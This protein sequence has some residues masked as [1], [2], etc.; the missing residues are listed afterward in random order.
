VNDA[1]PNAYGCICE[2]VREAVLFLDKG[3]V[4]KII[5]KC[6][7]IR[8]EE[9]GLGWPGSSYVP[10]TALC[11]HRNKTSVNVV[12]YGFTQSGIT[13]LIIHVDNKFIYPAIHYVDKAEG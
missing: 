8:V 13:Y 9:S 6:I 5:L 11:N 2:A 12:S 3:E 10:V 4:E 7:K 1:R